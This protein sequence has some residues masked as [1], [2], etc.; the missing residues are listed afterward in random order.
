MGEELPRTQPSTTS[1]QRKG[2]SLRPTCKLW[3]PGA[4][5]VSSSPLP[6]LF[7]PWSLHCAHFTAS[8]CRGGTTEDKLFMAVR[9][10]VGLY[11]LSFYPSLLTTQHKLELE[12]QLCLSWTPER[13]G[14]QVSMASAELE[15]SSCGK[16]LT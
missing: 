1:H 7:Q 9:P 8:K 3:S 11:L 16:A 12:E 4:W 6:A 10:W 15:S 13:R 2:N 5:P 14:Q